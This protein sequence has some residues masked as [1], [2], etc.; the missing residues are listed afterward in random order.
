MS[1]RP[2]GLRLPRK[3]EC[4]GKM[5][6]DFDF[7]IVWSWCETCTPLVCRPV[8]ESQQMAPTQTQQR[9]GHNK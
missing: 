1:K 9:S 2:K 7:G 5:G 6:Y 3:C 4:G 8:V